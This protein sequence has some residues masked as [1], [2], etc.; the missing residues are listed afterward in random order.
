MR[1]QLISTPKRLSG[2]VGVQRRKPGP[3]IDLADGFGDGEVRL[4]GRVPGDDGHGIPDVLAVPGEVMTD[5]ANHGAEHRP[6][7]MREHP[8]AMLSVR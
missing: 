1:L 2:A 3:L 6:C 5:C 8:G 4:A 7:P